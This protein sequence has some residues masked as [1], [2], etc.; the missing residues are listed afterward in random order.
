MV[1]GAKRDQTP[2]EYSGRVAARPRRF[3]AALISHLLFLC[4]SKSTKNPR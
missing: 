4:T 2:A 3:I 1:V